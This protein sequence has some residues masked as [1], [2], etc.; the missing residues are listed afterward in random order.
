[1][2]R[3]RPAFEAQ[4]TYGA[5]TIFRTPCNHRVICET[6]HYYAGRLVHS[7]GVSFRDESAAQRFD[8]DATQPDSCGQ[9]WHTFPSWEAAELWLV[10]GCLVMPTAQ[11]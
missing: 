6:A 5:R 3:G 11:P 4:V 8:L 10:Q 1:M 7:D 9:R 2:E